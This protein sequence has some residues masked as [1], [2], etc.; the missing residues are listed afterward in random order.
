MTQILVEL[1]APLPSYRWESCRYEEALQRNA[2][3]VVARD[4]RGAR[5]ENKE[6]VPSI[7]VSRFGEECRR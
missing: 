3:S 6:A 7:L 2:L 1:I 5:F 4:H